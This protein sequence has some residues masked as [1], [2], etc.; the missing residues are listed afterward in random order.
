MPRNAVIATAVPGAGL[1]R[2]T[3]A[4][5]SATLT[6]RDGRVLVRHHYLRHGRT[7][8]GAHERGQEPPP[9]SRW[10]GDDRRHHRGRVAEAPP[11]YAVWATRVGRATV[12]REVDGDAPG[13]LRKVD[14]ATYCRTIWAPWACP[15]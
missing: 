3:S 4:W 12:E 1:R 11:A 9:A 2:T 15:A 13:M 5:L 7:C 10:A 14:T 8:A 6:L